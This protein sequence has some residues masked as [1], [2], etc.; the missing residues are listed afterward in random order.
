[1]LILLVTFN[2]P[3][4][5]QFQASGAEDA[6]VKGISIMRTWE[7]NP[8]VRSGIGKIVSLMEKVGINP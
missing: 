8:L 7:D 6:I 4:L 1:M 3:E 2:V 5:H